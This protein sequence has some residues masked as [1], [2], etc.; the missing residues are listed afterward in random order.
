MLCLTFLKSFAIILIIHVVDVGKSMWDEF[1]E[2]SF[3]IIPAVLKEY[4]DYF[5]LFNLHFP[6]FGLNVGLKKFAVK[7]VQV[8]T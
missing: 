8:L 3:P 7:Y 4:E 1:M 2:P 5:L 6:N